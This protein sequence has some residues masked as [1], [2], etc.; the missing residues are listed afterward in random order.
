[1]HPQLEK[2]YREASPAH[3][4]LDRKLSP[5]FELIQN[6]NINCY[7]QLEP[8]EERVREPAI[9]A[10]RE[11][12]SKL[13]ETAKESPPRLTGTLWRKR[14]STPSP[15]RPDNP[16]RIFMVSPV[17]KVKRH[18]IDNIDFE[19]MRTA[20]YHK[21]TRLTRIDLFYQTLALRAPQPITT[22]TPSPPSPYNPLATIDGSFRITQ[23]KKFWRKARGQQSEPTAQELAVRGLSQL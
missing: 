22:S 5:L 13:S 21:P 12:R 4:S 20:L 8:R 9:F 16:E 2:Y 7:H 1:M 18:L 19:S 11:V 23:K 3:N 6:E 15:S 14:H 10:A 17:S